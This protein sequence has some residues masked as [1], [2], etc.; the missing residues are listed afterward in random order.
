MGKTK[1]S[2]LQEIKDHPEWHRHDFNGLTACCLINGAVDVSLMEA[3]S[4]YADIGINGGIRCDVVDGPCV[5][6][7][8]H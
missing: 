1:E 7:A 5:C 8:W 2:V 4:Q 3:H 6:G